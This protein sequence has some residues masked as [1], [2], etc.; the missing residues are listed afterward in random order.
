MEAWTHYFT[1]KRDH[2]HAGHWVEITANSNK[3]AER[4]M[5]ELYG[6]CWDHHYSGYVMLPYNRY[7]KGCLARHD[8]E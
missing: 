1:F 5:R 3:K 4:S 2:E 6:D 7:P 8:I